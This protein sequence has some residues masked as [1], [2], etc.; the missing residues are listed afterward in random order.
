MCKA[1][2]D[3]FLGAS[4][5]RCL[6]SFLQRPEKRLKSCVPVPLLQ[7]FILFELRLQL[8]MFT[9][10]VY[11]EKLGK[12]QTKTNTTEIKREENRKDPFR[13]FSKSFHQKF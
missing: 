1:M 13:C 4:H 6:L 3:S 9:P 8:H 11:K 7:K 5:K 10:T 2:V 12:K